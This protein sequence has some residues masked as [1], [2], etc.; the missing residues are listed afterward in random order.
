MFR[1]GWTWA[2]AFALLGGATLVQF[3]AW[4]SQPGIT[5]SSFARLEP[6]TTR[7]EAEAILGAP[8]G[9]TAPNG[10]SWVGLLL[11]WGKGG[12]TREVWGGDDAAVII[13]FDARG[14]LCNKTWIDAE[15]S[16]RARVRRHLPW[17]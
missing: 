3:A 10:R 4:S 2:A 6:G 17:F 14:R 11:L 15:D 8:P 12:Y 16:F 9:V 13:E 7:A 1:N 5:S